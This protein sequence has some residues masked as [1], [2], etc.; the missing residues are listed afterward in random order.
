MAA[1]AQF[2]FKVVEYGGKGPK[3][4]ASKQM[5]SSESGI[6]IGLVDQSHY[7]KDHEQN[8]NIDIN[9]LQ[10]LLGN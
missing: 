1:A 2:D 10:A 8:R 3:T 5:G 6:H 9:E 4:V 7:S